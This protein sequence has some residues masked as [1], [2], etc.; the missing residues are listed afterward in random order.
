MTTPA[1]YTGLSIIKSALRA[2]QSYQ[3]GETLAQADQ[4]DCLES[5]NMLLDS[6]SLDNLYIYGSQ[7]NIFSWVSGQSQYRIGNPT[8][9]QL[10]EPNFTGTVT[11]GSATITSVTNIPSDLAAGS[12]LTD[13]GNCIPSGTT[14]VSFG[15]GQIV[16]S[17]SAT[18]TPSVNPDSIGYTVPGDFVMNRPN[19]ITGGY[20]RF[21]QLDYTLDIR[22]TQDEY[23]SILYKAQ[24]GPWPVVGWYNDGFP[25]GQLNVYQTPSNSASVHLFTDTI[26]SNVSLTDTFQLPMG[27]A[28]AL[29]WNLALQLWP[30]YKGVDIPPMLLKNAADALDRIK[31]L[32]AEPA[33]VSQ[34]DEA[35]TTSTGGDYGWV[36]HGGYGR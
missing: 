1:V 9:A 23:N 35:L 32:N 17:A 22:A 33:M 7:E 14:V 3:S 26:L 2:V 20:T 19:R 16:M 10:G 28:M 15:A 36:T 13:V 12:T 25:Y 21:S 5:L 24:P 30:E 27:Y 11:G 31:A 4:T 29:K 18:A 8:N 6:W 34:Y